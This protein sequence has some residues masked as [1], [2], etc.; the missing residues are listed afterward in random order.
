MVVSGGGAHDM[1]LVE[2]Y[3]EF[4]QDEPAAGP[5]SQATTTATAP[6][7]SSSAAAAASERAT[8]CPSCGDCFCEKEAAALAHHKRHCKPTY[9]FTLQDEVC[10]ELVFERFAMREVDGAPEACR[11][12]R[13]RVFECPWCPP[14][15]RTFLQGGHLGEHLRKSCPAAKQ[16]KFVLP[17]PATVQPTSVASVPQSDRRKRRRAKVRACV[18]VCCV[19]VSVCLSVVPRPPFPPPAPPHRDIPSIHHQQPQ[20]PHHRAPPSSAR[21]TPRATPPTSATRPSSASP[22]SPTMSR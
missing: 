16:Q 11:P 5:A 13:V 8:H 21:P 17:T 12:N 7:A 15:S 22:A 14:V 9:H 18:C 10:V 6:A 4:E 1:E 3:D 20:S 2:E 19:S